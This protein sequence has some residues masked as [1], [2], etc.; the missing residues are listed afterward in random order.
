MMK[1]TRVYFS[2]FIILLFSSIYGIY[3]LLGTDILNS[4]YIFSPE[5]LQANS[6]SSINQ[7][8]N[9]TKAIVASIVND[10]RADSSI[11]PYLSLTEE[12]IFN[13]AGGAMGAMYIIH[14]SV[15]NPFPVIV[16]LV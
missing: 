11:S 16:E 12:W 1:N 13:N 2:S 9:D 6:L 15:S 5:T 7:H 3:C 8:G 4:Y 14:A 10:L